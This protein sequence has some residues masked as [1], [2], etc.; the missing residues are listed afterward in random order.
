MKARGVW[1]ALLG[2]LAAGGLAV[3]GGAVLVRSLRTAAP[4]YDGPGRGSVAVQVPKGASAA[5]IG[6]IL[7]ERNVVRSARAFTKVARGDARALSIQPGWYDMRLEMRARLALDRL[8]DPKARIR[9]RFVVPEGTSVARTLDIIAKSVD[10][11]P[12][13]S[14]QEA[15]GNPAALG[16]PSWASGAGGRGLEGLLF[17]ATYD[18]EPGTSA[19]EVLTTMVDRFAVAAAAV[20]LEERATALKL[21]PY[22]LLTVASLVEG[23]VRHD[24]ER[25]KVARVVYNRLA[26]GKRLEFDSTVKYAWGLRG[27]VKTRLLNRDLEIDSPY[28]TYRRAGL[29]PGPI[30]SPGEAALRAAA[31]PA[32]GSWL[33]FVVVDKAGHTAFA[34]TYQDF[35]A[36]KARYRRDVLGED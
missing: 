25:P 29:P 10:G 15:A 27:E 33:Y 3:G 26:A 1:L 19:V 18:V 34:T 36:L 9:S 31:A 24:D 2:L 20:G 11:M 21:T 17:P 7:A 6:A 8:L 35:L 14:L 16:L 22:E 12:L 4:D 23:E 5:R 28:N 32:A 13:A 30:N